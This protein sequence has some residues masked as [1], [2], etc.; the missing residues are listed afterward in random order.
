MAG[1]YVAR[2]LFGYSALRASWRRHQIAK[3]APGTVYLLHFSKPYKHARRYLG[4][5]ESSGFLKVRRRFF[6]GGFR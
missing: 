6:A 2:P 1:R 5:S 4:T 3:P